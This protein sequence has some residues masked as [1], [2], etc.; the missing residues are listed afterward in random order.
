M[1]AKGWNMCAEL[2]CFSFSSV[3]FNCL[4]IHVDEGSER[5]HNNN[6]NIT[7]IGFYCYSG[8][9]QVVHRIF[10]LKCHF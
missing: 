3:A 6:L 10:K 2:A 5:I 1:S 8:M 9:G 4:N 7:V